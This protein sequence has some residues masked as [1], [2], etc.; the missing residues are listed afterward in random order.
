MGAYKPKR[1][2]VYEASRS[3]AAPMPFQN[4]ARP[5]SLKITPT[6][7]ETPNAL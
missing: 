3:H 2:E 7:P 5:S 4:A 6:V 1:R